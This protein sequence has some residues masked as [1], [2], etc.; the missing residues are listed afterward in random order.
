MR[1]FILVQNSAVQAALVFEI[2]SCDLYHANCERYSVSERP[3]LRAKSSFIEGIEPAVSSRDTRSTRF[4]GKKMVGSPMRSPSGSFSWRIK[5]SK[6]FK[7]IPRSVTP[8]GLM[9]NSSPQTF[10]LGECKLT[11]T[12]EWGSISWVRILLAYRV[13]ELP[14]EG[15]RVAESADTHR[16]TLT[17]EPCCENGV[18]SR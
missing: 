7:S 15:G 2:A 5:W 14:P 9:S 3:I 16:S 13:Q 1:P 6:E 12:I 4:I 10:S 18:G 8:E 17:E 11:T